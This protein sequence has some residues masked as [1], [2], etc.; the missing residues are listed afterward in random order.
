VKKER[1]GWGGVRGLCDSLG[2]ETSMHSVGCP[3]Q[4][5]RPQLNV[6]RYHQTE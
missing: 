1:V 3:V 2:C 6:F 4:S 5:K